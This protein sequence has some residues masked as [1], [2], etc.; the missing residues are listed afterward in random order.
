MRPSAVE[1]I[2]AEANLANAPFAK[3]SVAAGARA[4]CTLKRRSL[5]IYILILGKLNSDKG[6]HQGL[7]GG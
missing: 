3:L 4:A 5:S 6:S 7:G 2:S 1:P